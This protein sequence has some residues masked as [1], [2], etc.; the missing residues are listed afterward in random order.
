MCKNIEKSMLYAIEK[1]DKMP[2]FPFM[3]ETLD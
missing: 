1:A 2:T 3:E